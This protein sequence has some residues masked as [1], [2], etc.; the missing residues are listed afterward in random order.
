MIEPP[1]GAQAGTAYWHPRKT[2]F[3]VDVIT[4]SQI[5]S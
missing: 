1:P 4:M 5:S 2:G 3:E